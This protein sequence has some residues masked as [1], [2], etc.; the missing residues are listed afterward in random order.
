MREDPEF[1]A[2][3]RRE[4][5]LFG[6]SP[7]FRSDDRRRRRSLHGVRIIVTEIKNGDDGNARLRG[8][9]RGDDPFDRLEEN[10]YYW[11]FLEGFVTWS[12]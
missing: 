3:E 2:P 1:S 9:K 12:P 7:V 5:T 10:N 11:S 8:R 4:G 6:P